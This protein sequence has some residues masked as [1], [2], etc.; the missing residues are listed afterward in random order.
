MK[1]CHMKHVTRPLTDLS[2]VQAWCC[3]TDKTFA[4]ASGQ[5]RSGWM[6]LQPFN[7]TLKK[8]IF[9]FRSL[10]LLPVAMAEWNQGVQ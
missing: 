3:Q 1:N 10:E 9:L 2:F 8:I 6:E 4:P 7:K 5:K